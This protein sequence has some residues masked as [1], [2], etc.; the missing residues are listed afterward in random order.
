MKVL[1]IYP[2]NLFGGIESLLITLAQARQLCP[3]MQPQ[4]ALCFEGRLSDD[5]RSLGVPVYKLGEVRT[6]RPWTVWRAR[7]QLR[8]LLQAESFDLVVCHACWSQA[9]FAPVVKRLGRPLVFFCHDVPQGQHWLERWAKL[10][11]P[12]FVLANS[13]FTQAALPKL[14]PQTSSQVFY[15]PVLHP[16]PTA[17]RS[18]VR[19]P[20]QTSASAVVIIQV[21]RL[22]RWKGQTVLLEALAELQDLPNWVC[23]IV[24]GDQRPQE[25]LYLE[26]LKAQAAEMAERVKFLGQRRNVPDLLAAADIFC[27]PNLSP[28]PFGIV[29]VEALLAGLPV[30]ATQIGGAAELISDRGLVPPADS[31]ALAAVLRP[32]IQ[33]PVARAELA[34][35]GRSRAKHLCDPAQQLQQLYK[36]LAR[37]V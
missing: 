18:A 21:S 31:K 34:Q 16:P 17:A 24:G 3:Q 33:N 10:T 37:V 32:L 8:Q 36:L 2:G 19:S 12:D 35:G 11:P 22:E 14:Y 26:A 9:M 6:S 5:L 13:Q 20:L 7:Q 27:Q 15:L 30:V 29:F 1:H 25:T 23:W 4:F 28:E